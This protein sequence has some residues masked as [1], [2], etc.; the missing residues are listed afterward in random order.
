MTDEQSENVSKLKPYQIILIS[1]LLGSILVVNSNYVNKNRDLARLNKQ[2]EELFDSIIQRRKLQSQNY[3]EEVCSR[4]SDDLIEY[5]KTGELSKIDLDEKGSIECKNKDSG[6]MKTLISIVRALASDDDKD[7]DNDGNGSHIDPLR[8]LEDLNTDDLLDYSLGRILP[9]AVFLVF[10]LL[11]FIGWIVCCFCCCCNCCCCCC[12]KKKTCKIPCFV[13]TYIFYVLVIVVCIYGLSQTNKIFVGLAD[14]ECSFLKFFDQVVDGEMKTTLPRW[15]GINNIQG[16]LININ[17]TIKDLSD[18]SYNDLNGYI[19]NITNK[20]KHFNDEMH[21]VGDKFYDGTTYKAP[22]VETFEGTTTYPLSG[23][24]IYDIVYNFGRYDNSQ[25][26]YTDNKSLIYAWNKEFSTI[27]GEAYDYL[28]TAQDGFKDILDENLGDVHKALGD[29][30]DTLDDLLEPFNDIKDD[31]GKALYDVSDLIDKY[32]KMGVNIVF[33]VLMAMNAALAVL[34]L[35]ISL[36]SGKS[37]TSCCCCRCLFKCCTHVLWNLLALLMI[38]AFLIG[39]LVALVGRLGGDMMG[40]LSYIMSIDNFN[41]T[42]P[43]LVN[44][45]DDA[46]DYIYTCLHG[47]GDIAKQIGLGESLDSFEEINNV[48][49]NITT[50]LNNF[51]SIMNMKPVYNGIKKSLNDQLNLKQD[52]MMIPQGGMSETKPP[53]R[54]SDLITKINGEIPENDR[55]WGTESSNNYECDSSSIPDSVLYYPK[56]CKPKDSSSCNSNTDCKKYA[57]ILDN[58]DN[59]V[60]YAND[61]DKVGDA[62]QAAS[63]MKVI[64]DLEDEYDSYLQC[65]V[66]ILNFFL[67]TIHKITDLIRVYSGDGNAFSFLNGKFIGTNLKIILKYLEH[68]LGGDFYTVGICLCIVGLSLILSISSTI[69]LIVIINI[70]LTENQQQEKAQNNR[71]NANTALAVSE[72]TANYPV[73]KAY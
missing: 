67:R 4:A 14:T 55:K 13:F 52:I 63:V 45:L 20:R 62:S 43:I 41:G 11:G 69:L 18:N 26:Q 7:S 57:A 35:L 72:Y 36:F 10:G 70:E 6:Y 47:D 39:S 61:P 9:M 15:A 54:Y 37:C 56:S 68:S 51:T 3:S 23:N 73:Q 33:G 25:N 50:V 32:G 40:I 49:S 12:C 31:A 58:I 19:T 46:K 5:Y 44:D 42:A 59:I 2:K 21:I 16:L 60:T 65:Y 28:K 22:Y 27:D 29:G 34:M 30:K 24:Y 71:N 53:I 17:N 8:N 64:N 48:E 1:C 66:D 38:L